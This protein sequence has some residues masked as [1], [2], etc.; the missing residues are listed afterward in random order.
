V[1]LYL[2][3][4]HTLPSIH[5]WQTLYAMESDLAPPPT[6]TFDSYEDLETTVQMFAK[7][8]GYAV[9]VG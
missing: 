4:F 3:Y 6:Q 7:E 5:Q 8:H 2:Q 1:P 9:V